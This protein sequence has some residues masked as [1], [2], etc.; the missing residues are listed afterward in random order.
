MQ[1]GDENKTRREGLKP[2]SRLSSLGTSWRVRKV[3]AS[4]S[5][6]LEPGRVHKEGFRSR[7]LVYDWMKSQKT[8]FFTG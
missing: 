5:T 6:R 7:V 8:C 1:N 4:V 2:R 3:A